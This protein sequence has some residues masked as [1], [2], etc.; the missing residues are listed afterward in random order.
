LPRGI[1]DDNAGIAWGQ[2]QPVEKHSTDICLSKSRTL[3]KLGR[4]TQDTLVAVCLE[5]L[6]KTAGSLYSTFQKC[7]QN[8]VASREVTIVIQEL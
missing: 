3:D 2:S 7:V 6:R 1:F 8:S 4:K 5:F